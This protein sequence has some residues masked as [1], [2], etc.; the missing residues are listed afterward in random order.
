MILFSS[1]ETELGASLISWPGLVTLV[2]LNRSLS[3]LEPF[4]LILII[5]A[6]VPPS[7]F[8]IPRRVV[9]PPP[10]ARHHASGHRVQRTRLSNSAQI[11]VNK[12]CS[13]HYQREDIVEDITDR[14][15][16]PTTYLGPPH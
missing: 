6:R 2:G 10:G 3:I 11:D 14:N 13:E 15:Q 12:N 1:K 9:G 8:A 5:L 7:R 16:K 4:D